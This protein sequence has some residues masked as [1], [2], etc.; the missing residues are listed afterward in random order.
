MHVSLLVA[1]LG[2]TPIKSNQG[3]NSLCAPED[4]PDDCL[5]LVALWNATGRTFK[6]KMDGKTSL[7]AWFDGSTA[8]EIG[9]RKSTGRVINVLIQEENMTGTIPSEIGYLGELQDWFV[10]GTDTLSGTLPSELGQLSNLG[11][12]DSGTD[13]RRGFTLQSSKISGTIPPEIGKLGKLHNLVLAYHRLSGTIPP[14]MFP[15]SSVNNLRGLGLRGN[16][17]SGTIPEKIC[18]IVKVGW[19]CNMCLLGGPDD[20]AQ[21]N[22]FQCPEPSCFATPDYCCYSSC[23]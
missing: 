4:D 13:Y 2:V 20:P 12:S 3:A 14:D 6:W 8:S 21:Y 15:T 10:T 16:Q 17:L 5:A 23:H 18:P 1:L 19:L 7:C 9:C 22:N 11:G